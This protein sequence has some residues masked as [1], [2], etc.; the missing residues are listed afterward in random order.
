MTSVEGGDRRRQWLEFQPQFNAGH[1]L[2][3]AVVVVTMTAA[4][5]MVQERQ[6]QLEKDLR[7]LEENAKQQQAAMA[8]SVRDLKDDFQRRLDG[9]TWVLERIDDKLDRKQDRV[10]Q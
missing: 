9:I 10:A 4:F 5:I 2:Q 8:A 1:V 6:N 3:A 7:R